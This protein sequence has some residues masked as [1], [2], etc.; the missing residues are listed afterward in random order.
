MVPNSAL[1]QS[2]VAAKAVNHAPII[3]DQCIAASQLP[4]HIQ[5]IVYQVIPA[6]ETASVK[7]RTIIFVTPVYIVSSV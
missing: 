6:G 2:I 1:N 4:I 7:K 3:N 5:V